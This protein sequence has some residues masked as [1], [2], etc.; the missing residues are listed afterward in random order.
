MSGPEILKRELV[1]D[2]TRAEGD[3]IPCTIATATPVMRG[4]LAEV[5]DCSPAGVDLTRAPLPL[6]VAHDQSR[7]SVGLVENL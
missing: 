2:G 1:L 4:N 3:L 6:I 7:L 5:L